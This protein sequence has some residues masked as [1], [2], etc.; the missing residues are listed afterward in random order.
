MGRN[1]KV[2]FQGGGPHAVYLLDGLRAQD[3]YN[4][5][6]INTPAFEEYYQSGLSVIMPVGGQSSFYSDWYQPACGK[7]GCQTY[8]WETFVTR[9][10]PLYLQANRGISPNG[11]AAVGLSMSGGSALILAAYYPQQFSYAGSLSGFLNPSEGWWPTLIGMAMNDAGG[12]NATNM[13][14]PSSDPA[15]KRNDPM[16]QLPRLVQNNTRIWVY[17]GNGTPTDIGGDSMPAKFLESFTLRTNET[18]RDNYAAAGGRNGVFNFP[19]N[20]T[21]DWGYW[22]QQLVAMK[23]DIQ[24]ALSGAPSAT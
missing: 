17:C 5:W 18:F 24:R 23:P 2:Q 12:Y 20:G 1:I 9:E 16:L 11:N 10:L 14:G 8:K 7:S 4:G 19:P 13:W 6:D 21:H 3:D 22:N 15:W